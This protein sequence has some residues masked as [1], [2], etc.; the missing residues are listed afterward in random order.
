MSRKK[1]T[2]H[3]VPPPL[4]SCTHRN[5]RKRTHRISGFPMVVDNEPIW[6]AARESYEKVRA[7]M[8]A[9]EQEIDAHWRQELPA[10]ERWIH[11]HF[12][13]EL[14]DLREVTI[15]ADGK[16]TFLDR[17]AYYENCCGMSLLEAYARVKS[18][19]ER[20]ETSGEGSWT[21]DGSFADD[22]WEDAE[23]DVLQA[24]RD[25][26]SQIFDGR[27]AE[28]EEELRIVYEMVSET[29]ADEIG[30]DAP[31]FETFRREVEHPER[32]KDRANAETERL[33]KLYRRLARNL[34][35]DGGREFSPR[36]QRLWH[37]AQDAYKNGDSR[38]L[39]IVLSQLDIEGSSPADHQTLSELRE[40]EAETRRR[41]S[42]LEEELRAL[43]QENCWGF[44]RKNEKQL[45]R[46][47]KRVARE[48]D[49]ALR[50][51]RSVLASVDLELADLEAAHNRALAKRKTPRRPQRAYV[52]PG[53]VAFNFDI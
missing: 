25:L 34:H 50:K 37:Q 32:E 19:S 20:T 5:R 14:T 51:A 43:Q 22:A 9:L 46:L 52:A 33:K 26:A 44:T 47:H 4:R 12:G 16:E 17:V 31:D 45:K 8:Q 27:S 30:L 40:L 2:K 42:L 49:S 13:P 53:Q 3:P 15:A 29:L 38:G 28:E 7:Q 48:L 11:L 21:P 24:W 18:E 39:E 6:R 1:K 10:Y 35:P 41:T 23:D 36:E